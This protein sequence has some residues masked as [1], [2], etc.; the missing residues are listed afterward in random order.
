MSKK[1][2]FWLDL[3]LTSFCLSYDLQKK[4]SG[5]YYAIIDCPNRVKP[6][7][8]TQNLVSFKKTWYYNDF[9]SELNP[10]IDEK[11]LSTFES[12][13]K[14]NLWNL[15]INERIFYRFNRLY[16]FSDLEILSILEKECKLF[17]MILDEIKPD[18]LITK[19]PPLHHQQLFYELCRAKG[20]RI[21][22]FSQP[23]TNGCIISEE[24][25]T[26]D[27]NNDLSQIQEKHRS[28]SEL[29]KEMES[30]SINPQLKNFIKHRSGKKTSLF[31]AAFEYLFISTNSNLKTN[32][33]F[34]GRTKSKVL[35][36]FIKMRLKKKFRK[37]F[38]NKNLLK[39]VSLSKNFVYFPLG[40]D[41]E[42]NLLVTAPFYQNQIELIRSIAKSLPMGYA[43]FVKENPFQEIRFWRSLNEYKEILSI[44]NVYLIHPNF[45]NVDLLTNCSLVITVVGSSGFEAAFYEK[46]SI[47]FSDT[48]YSI[49]PSVKR[50][51]S[52]ENLPLAIREML[53]VKVKNTDL[54]RYVTLLEKNLIKFDLLDFET[55]Y[56]NY[57]YFSGNLQDVVIEIDKM[58]EFLNE[59][60]NLMEPL[61]NGYIEKINTIH[62]KDM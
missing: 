50:V 4:L 54:D 29:R 6:F 62:I 26:I 17:E 37:Y 24:I 19:E 47:V 33:S 13:Y 49:L 60:I 18:C 25:R 16:K 36:D 42:R 15:A 40:V 32:Y 48:G 46:P 1:I 20:I 58:K 53:Q 14:L 3:D 56:Q 38:I 21:M 5:D 27:G 43:L 23:N 10:V 12:K 22:M 2:L 28:F 8:Q 59:N 34:F 41:E 45:S 51:Y 11:F 7:F 61:T 31:K 9:L 35:I 55:R 52:I 44:P 39:S 30:W 57:F